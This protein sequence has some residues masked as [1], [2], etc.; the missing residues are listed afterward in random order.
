MI[1]FILYLVTVIGVLAMFSCI[2][3]EKQNERLKNNLEKLGKE[4]IDK[5]EKESSH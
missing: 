2:H 1:T 3:E 5:L 4:T